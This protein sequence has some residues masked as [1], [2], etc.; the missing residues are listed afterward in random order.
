MASATAETTP[1]SESP[2]YTLHVGDKFTVNGQ[3]YKVTD[4]KTSTNSEGQVTRSATFKQLGNGKTVSFDKSAYITMLVVQGG[5]PASVSYTPSTG[6]ITLAEEKYGAYYP[7]NNTVKLMTNEVYSKEFSTTKSLNERFKGL[8][9]VT[10]LG[11]LAAIL[12][13]GLSYLPR[14]G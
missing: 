8:W 2:A 10:V 12:I 11:S 9:A 7:N 5:L 1:V 3:E 14:R 4:I 6:T 13:I